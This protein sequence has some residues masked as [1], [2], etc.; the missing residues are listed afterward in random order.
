MIDIKELYVKKNYTLKRVLSKL[1]KTAQGVLFLVDDHEQF[2]RTITDGDVRRLLLKEYTLESNLE[3][4]PTIKSKTLPSSATAQDA[5]QLMQEFELD[6]IPI[7]DEQNRP[8]RLIHRRDL[9]ANI[10]LSSPHIG[11][12]EQ[13]Y[14]QEAFATNWVAPP[15][16]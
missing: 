11:E 14:V 5:Y 10:H 16:P 1:D 9:S 15:R 2:L 3:T 13:R 12:Y 6:H 8:V 4:L 7:L